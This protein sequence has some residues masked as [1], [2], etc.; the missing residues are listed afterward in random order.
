L[1]PPHFPYGPKAASVWES[2]WRIKIEG[3]EIRTLAPA[4]A[5]LFLCVHHSK[6]GWVSLGWIA[7]LAQ[8]IRVNPQLDAL[9]CF[10]QAERTGCL[11]MLR[12]GLTLVRE[13]AEMP[14]PAA[15]AEACEGDPVV[16][17][18]ARQIRS[19]LFRTVEARPS[20]FNDWIV[21]LRT[22]DT[23]R[24]RVRYCVRRALTPTIDDRE[25]IDLPGKLTPLYALLR[26]LRLAL[27]QG[28][29]LLGDAPP[30]PPVKPGKFAR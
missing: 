22:I 24:G 10:R 20:L 27:Q 11:R 8:L 1:A 14:L 2:A 26:P 4:D 9:S 12:L 19:R 25:F 18:L 30:A 5:L 13:F 15:F 17:R 21:P 7:D 3:V 29:R 16:K 23:V 6:H 28:R